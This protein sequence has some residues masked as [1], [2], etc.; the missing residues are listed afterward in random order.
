MPWSTVGPLVFVWWNT[1]LS[2][3][4]SKRKATETDVQFVVEQLRE[5]RRET[6]FAVLALGEV[7]SD[8]LAAIVEGLGDQRL[9]IHD[10]TDRSTRPMFD[11]AVIYDSSRLV[12]EGSRSI[13]D[14]FARKTLKTGEVIQFRAVETDDSFSVV[15]SHWPS[16]LT[17]SETS[18][19]R[20]EIG[21]A[22]R[23]EVSKMH[24]AQ[25]EPYVV[26][27]G[28]YNDDPF[29]PSMADHL[30]ATRDRAL[31]RR[32]ARFLYNPFWR[33]IG[34]SHDSADNEETTGICGTHFYPG[35]DSSRWFTYDQII[36]SSAFLRDRSL[37]LS[38]NLC[39]ILTPADLCAKVRSR[40]EIFDHLP[41]LGTVELRS[42][43]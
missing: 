25:D 11:T 1:S 28:D 17:A 29:S 30:L 27:L 42:R 2:P 32:D 6:D 35:G 26:L 38:E 40:R 9:S 19:V 14:R 18:P 36:F 34:Q 13:I 8:D 10:S 23:Q 7:C 12:L 33:R 5:I 31:A 16:R 37:A 15:V 3:P 21:M 43:S 22:L 20:A 39:G 4:V 24:E 41:V